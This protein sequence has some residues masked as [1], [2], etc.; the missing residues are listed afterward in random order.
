MPEMSILWLRVAVALYSIGLAHAIIT[1]LSR[2]AR[3]F[4]I[5][6]A[7]FSIGMVLHMVA[8]VE[9]W[10]GAARFPAGNF[11]ESASLC[12]FLLGIAFL[13]VYWRYQFSSLAVFLFPLV[14]L[15]TLVGATEVP[16]AGFTNP[17][18]RS[19]WL[20]THIAMV[21]LAYAS[22]VLMAVASIFYLI[23]ERKLKSKTIGGLFD[24]LPPL[25]T[26]DN[27]ISKSMAIG[28]VLLTLATIA[29]TT[30]A[31]VESGTSWIGD[32]KIGISLAT[33][34]LTLV[35][36]FLRT[37]AGWRGRKAA[38]MALVVIG[39]SALTW[40]THNGIAALAK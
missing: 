35:M 37:S 17:N 26:L 2:H 32:P 28:F 29:G 25:Y 24:R 11:F 40:A 7:A 15:L 36:V 3:M 34:A 13:V 23:Q 39:C 8:L 30:W 19:A 12:G 38:M 22:L 16:V 18:V 9:L 1:V 27:I 5:G 14:F 6:L 21:L 20:Y 31:F 10:I 33:W 4:S